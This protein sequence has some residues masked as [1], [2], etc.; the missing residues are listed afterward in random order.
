MPRAPLFVFAL[1]D[2]LSSPKR[3]RGRPS[4]ATKWLTLDEAAEF[5]R[6]E[7]QELRRMLDRV[8]DA[9]PGATREDDGS[10]SVPEKALR[11]V[12]GVPTG[13]LPQFVTVAD[14]ATAFRKSVKTVY[15]W[16]RVMQPVKS[17]TPKPMLPHVRKLGTIYILASDV[18]ALPSRMPGPRPS[19]FVRKEAQEAA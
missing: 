19:F 13:P 1:S 8:P 18:L 12:F 4:N 2:T 11:A 3:K 15:D 6:F 16:L 14:V 10:W 17:G 9:L 7:P 5:L